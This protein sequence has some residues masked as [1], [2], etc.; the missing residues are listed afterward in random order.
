MNY[1]YADES[2]SSDDFNALSANLYRYLFNSLRSHKGTDA[3]EVGSGRGGGCE[4]LLEYLPGSVTG[5]DFSKNAVEFCRKNY[6]DKCLKFVPGSAENLPFGNNSFD[7][8]YN[9]ESSH[10]YGDRAA[11]F[12]EVTR[13]LKP[14]GHFLYADFMSRRHYPK[15]IALLKASGLQIVSEHDITPAVLKSMSLGSSSK[16]T[17]LKKM[18]YRPFRGALSD[19]VGLPGSDIHRKFMSG[20]VVYFFILC[21]KPGFNEAG[22]VQN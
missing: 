6:T 15:R 10:C 13:T 11:F 22:L 20:D 9:V 19:F 21:R 5:I 16:E 2:T 4:L 7:M 12:K 17:L 8:I 14:E 3:L 18:V 1:G